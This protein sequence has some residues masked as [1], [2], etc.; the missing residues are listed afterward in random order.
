MI[1]SWATENKL[2]G[3]NAVQRNVNVKSI[4]WYNPELK[5][6]YYMVPGIIVLL[7]T[8]VTIMLTALAIVKE[9]EAGT[10]EQLL[11]TPIKKID[12]ILGK[13]IPF[14]IL[15]ILE[16]C[17]ALAVSHFVY[18]I[19]IA[20]SVTLFLLISVLYIF[21]HHR[22]RDTGFHRYPDPAAGAFSGLVHNDFLPAYERVHASFGKHA[23]RYL[24][25]N[26]S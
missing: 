4:I 14:G 1:Y 23:R 12:L 5:N 26:L 8:I 25:S 6:L 15:G 22:Y 11:V 19:T 21:L 13:T 20:G 10:L 24:L 7:V 16:L 2:T 9:R 18:N 3:V 17:L